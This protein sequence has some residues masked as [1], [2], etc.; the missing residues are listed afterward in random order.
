MLANAAF[1]V[2]LTLSVAREGAEWTARLPFSR[3][4]ANF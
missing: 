1:L 3:A 2:G 4:H